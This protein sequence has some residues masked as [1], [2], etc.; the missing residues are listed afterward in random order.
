VSVSLTDYITGLH[1]AYGAVMALLKRNET[2]QGQ[3]IDA[4]LFECAFN[5]ME[6]YVP[7]YEKLGV[8]AGWKLHVKG[9]SSRNF[10]LLIN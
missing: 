10:L 9:Y 8:V 3:C 4:A 5:F 2:G 6:P 1:A 7:A